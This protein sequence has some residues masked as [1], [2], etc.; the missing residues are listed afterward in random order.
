MTF[1]PGSITHTVGKRTGPDFKPNVVCAGE[2]LLAEDN[3]N[4]LPSERPCI[5]HAIFKGG[6]KKGAACQRCQFRLAQ[7]A[8]G[9][10]TP[11][12]P[13]GMVAKLKAACTPAIAE[14]LK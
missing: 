1:R 8:A 14:L 5:W 10:A 3:P 11:P 6:C 2:Q 4:T 9:K 13:A 12:I 7:V